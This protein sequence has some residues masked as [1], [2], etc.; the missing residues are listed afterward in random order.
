M[1]LHYLGDL[2]TR[3]IAEQENVAESTVRVWLHRGRAA[4]AGL[5]AERGTEEAHA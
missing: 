4:L 2:T 3:E 5:L 1:V